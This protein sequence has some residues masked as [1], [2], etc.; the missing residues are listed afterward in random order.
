MGEL[1][2]SSRQLFR[3]QEVLPRTADVKNKH[4]VTAN[5]IQRPIN[6]SSA[7]LEQYLAHFEVDVI[8]LDRQG[9]SVCFAFQSFDGIS[10]CLSPCNSAGLRPSRNVVQD[11]SKIALSASEN[12]DTKCHSSIASPS[13]RQASCSTSRAG[14]PV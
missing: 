12:L 8:A 4:L 14:L 5:R 2:V 13:S 9:S 11:L 1:P 7:R 6:K 10:E 3:R